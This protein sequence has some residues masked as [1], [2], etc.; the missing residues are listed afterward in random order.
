MTK[1][2]F[3]NAVRALLVEQVADL[4]LDDK[5][6]IFQQ[7]CIAAQEAAGFDEGNKGKSWT[8]EELRVV[9]Q[10]APTKENCMLLA[11]AFRRGYGSIEQIFRW[12]A[13][14]DDEVGAKRPDDAFIQQ[15]KRI[16]RQVGWRAT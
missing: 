6:A 13:S 5:F 8:D 7:C 2:E 4:S 10:Q 12:A 14:T 11:R 9:L 3:R 1:T 16:G 15:I